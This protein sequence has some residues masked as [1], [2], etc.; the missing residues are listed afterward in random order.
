MRKPCAV[1]LLVTAFAQFTFA[2]DVQYKFTAGYYSATG[3]GWPHDLGA[4]VNLR[5]TSRD[6]NTWLAWYRSPAEQVSQPRIGWDHTYDVHSDWRLQPSVQVASGGFV[7]GSVFAETGK[8][9]VLG[10]GL[11]R[12]NLRP[13]VNLNFDPNDAWIASVGYRW[14]TQQSLIVQVVRDNRNN[15][16]QQNRHWVYR[17]PRPDG[18]RIV[19]DVF[20]KSGTVEDRF[21]RQTGWSLGYDWSSV[22]VRV[23]RDPYVNFTPQTMWRASVGTRF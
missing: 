14:N 5:R 21:I 13:Y 23:A 20:Q 6:G 22:F 2:Q 12:T 4:D 9:W 15:P 10:A 19:I 16:D 3:G 1:F 11:G 18:E 8:H 7:G 17:L